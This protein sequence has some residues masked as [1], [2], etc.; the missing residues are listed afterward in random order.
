MQVSQLASQVRERVNSSSHDR[1]RS[2]KYEV[3]KLRE[4]LLKVEEEVKHLN[5]GRR[6]LELA[7]EDIR[8]AI[9]VNQQSHS[10]QLKRTRGSG[11]SLKRFSLLKLPPLSLTTS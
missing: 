6:T 10:S 9:S 7:V 4:H 3:A 2:L 11:V 8:R 1:I 5:R